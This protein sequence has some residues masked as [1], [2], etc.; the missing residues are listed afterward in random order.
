MD[1][2]KKRWLLLGLLEPDKQLLDR[3]Q[4]IQAT[5]AGQLDHG[6]I[7]CGDYFPAA[8]TLTLARLSKQLPRRP[9]RPAQVDY[10]TTGSTPAPSR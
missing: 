4:K 10:H 9:L 1:K 3:R 6:S 7:G 8:N 2:R 5:A